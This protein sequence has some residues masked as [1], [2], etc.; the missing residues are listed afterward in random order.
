MQELMTLYENILIAAGGEIGDDGIPR[1]MTV[2]DRQ[3]CFIGDKMLVMPTREIQREGNWS[4]RIAFHPVSENIVRGESDVVKKLKQLIA[5]RLTGSI[6]ML[7]SNLMA[8]A[9]DT[10]QQAKLPASLATFLTVIPDVDE[11]TVRNT[12]AV[13]NSI[14]SVGQNRLISIYLKRKGMHAG[15]TWHRLATV[16]FP[17]V[18]EFF[19]EER[20]IYGRTL[21]KKDKA[22]FVNLF[23]WILPDADDVTKYSFGSADMTAP[24]F[25]ALMG[26]FVTVA[27]RLNTVSKKFKKFLPDYDA[28]HI[29]LE[30]ADDLQDLGKYKDMIAPQPGNDGPPIKGDSE[31][32]VQS[33]QEVVNKTTTT[34][35]LGQ[36]IPQAPAATQVPRGFAP[37]SPTVGQTTIQP[38]GKPVNQPQ[39]SADD[40]M[41]F[42]AHQTMPTAIQP[43]PAANRM[44]VQY[45]QSYPQQQPPFAPFNA[46][47]VTRH[48]GPT[49]Q[50][51]WPM[52]GTVTTI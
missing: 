43:F 41:N 12:A 16:T 15:R 17:I 7:M 44:P 2:N 10:D 21:R 46:V 4:N 24:Y 49:D 28:I 9:A 20:D 31:E 14:E 34:Q 36:P 5:I 47:G 37:P 13:L 52:Q 38:L 25:H 3:P 30:W 33:A 42:M 40:W 27:T 22:A 6:S 26:A 50:Q 11:T 1:F 48:N 23:N 45:P 39:T 29:P 8:L 35:P 32:E 51:G 19:K 18:E